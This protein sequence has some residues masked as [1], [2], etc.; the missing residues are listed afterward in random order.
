MKSLYITFSFRQSE[1]S[2]L[3]ELRLR[4]FKKLKK[5]VFHFEEL[6][7]NSNGLTSVTLRARGD[8]KNNW[9][10]GESVLATRKKSSRGVQKQTA[11]KS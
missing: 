2:G 7:K 1:A 9:H 11:P 10:R 6:K 8:F 5:I 4:V 3:R